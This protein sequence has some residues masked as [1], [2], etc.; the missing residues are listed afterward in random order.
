MSKI[1]IY[2]KNTLP[3]TIPT[4]NDFSFYF[5]KNT[6]AETIYLPEGQ[7]SQVNFDFNN[8]FLGK[9]KPDNSSEFFQ[10]NKVNSFYFKTINGVSAKNNQGYI[11]LTLDDVVKYGGTTNVM[12]INNTFLFSDTTD[13]ATVFLG[14]YKAELNGLNNADKKAYIKNKFDKSVMVGHF[15]Y[16]SFNVNQRFAN[17]AFLVNK[18]YINYLTVNNSIFI[19]NDITVQEIGTVNIYD[20]NLNIGGSYIDTEALAANAQNKIEGNIFIKNLGY[21]NTTSDFK[22]L[23]KLNLTN[24][25]T[26]ATYTNLD[27][28]FRLP[29]GI[30]QKINSVQFLK[31][32]NDRIDGLTTTTQTLQSGITNNSSSLQTLSD[33]FTEHKN[34]Y[35][36]AVSDR[37]FFIG[38][39]VQSN[40]ETNSFSINLNENNVDYFQNIFRA[41]YLANEQSFIKLNSKLL[42]NN[43]FIPKTGGDPL[44]N[45]YLSFNETTGEV[46]YAYNNDKFFTEKYNYLA[47]INKP[48]TLKVVYNSYLIN[49]HIENT[50]A[51]YILGFEEIV[52]TLSNTQIDYWCDNFNHLPPV[53]INGGLGQGQLLIYTKKDE[54]NR[55]YIKNSGSDAYNFK[56]STGFQ[57]STVAF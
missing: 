18:L 24:I 35:N 55:V 38:F 32:V 49:F 11:N 52:L 13:T 31:P 48:I 19:G 56:V 54:P 15:G 41:K 26:I 12:K 46:G 39:N 20:N 34:Y 5:I 29:N 57:V 3:N 6:I 40:Y 25:D 1:G 37:R 33:K 36:Y 22:L 16:N 47:S 14:S 53:E 2:F 9:R 8:I 21:G 44:F 42:L 7:T 23:P 17:S 27:M 4:G 45:N 30:V 51:I 28:L 43:A 10:I 50:T